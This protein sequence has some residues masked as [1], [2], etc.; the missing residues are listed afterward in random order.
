MNS[1]QSWLKSL[2]RYSAALFLGIFLL[3]GTV[4]GYS[5]AAQAARGTNPLDYRESYQT[6]Q[7]KERVSNWNIEREGDKSN[8][9]AADLDKHPQN[10]NLV[11]EADQG[12]GNTRNKLKDAAATIRN[13]LNSDK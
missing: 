1:L 11:D 13:K 4:L 5:N 6:D 3:V 2:R 8:P 7:Q 10:P 9:R 12:T